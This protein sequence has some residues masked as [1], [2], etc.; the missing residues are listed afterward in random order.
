MFLEH[1]D[2][3]GEESATKDAVYEIGTRRSQDGVD[4]RHRKR[5]PSS[6][7]TREMHIKSSFFFSMW[8]DKN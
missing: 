2:L 5:H 8:V 7:I 1:V 4:T 6:I 3:R